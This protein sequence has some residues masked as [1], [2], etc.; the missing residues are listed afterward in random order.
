MVVV[1]VV[2]G[3][4]TVLVEAGGA[5]VIRQVHA[6]L[7]LLAGFGGIQVGRGQLRFS[8]AGGAAQPA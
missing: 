2:Y 7:I 4:T 5:E 1:D 3:T 8:L 6:A